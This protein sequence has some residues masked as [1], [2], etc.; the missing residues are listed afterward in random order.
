MNETF[1]LRNDYIALCDLLKTC[2]VCASGGE[3]KHFIAEGNVAVDGVQEL[4]KTCK[5]RPGQVVSGDGFTITV[6][7]A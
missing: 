3:A 4:R 1:A 2:S 7:A 6:V 5:I